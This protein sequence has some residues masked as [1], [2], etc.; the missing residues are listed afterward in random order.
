MALPGKLIL[1]GANYAPFNLHGVGVFMAFTGKGVY[2]NKGACSAIPNVGPLPPGKYW[3]VERGAGGPGSWVKAKAQDLY[4]TF[5]QGAEFG[6]DEWFALY[7]DDWGIDD[8]PGSMVF[9]VDCLGFIQV[10]FLRVV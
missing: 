2:R 4:N 1:N 7:K 5:Y 10:K 9:I 3:I 8:G 6:R